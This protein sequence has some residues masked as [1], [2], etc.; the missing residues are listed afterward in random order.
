MKTSVFCATSLD[1]FLAREDGGMDWLPTECEPHGY[2]EFMAS[3]DAV[4]IGRKTFEW[5]QSYGQWV[6]DKPVVVLSSTLKELTWPKGVACELMSAS[7]REVVDRLSERGMKHL[8][9]DGGVTIRRFLEAGF[10]DSM[11]ITRIPILL[12][13]G[14]P[15]FGRLPQD[16]RFRHVETKAFPSGLVNS[17]YVSAD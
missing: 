3:V 8:Y 13:S 1:G 9:V 4:V 2:T 14:I 10:I 5:V 12:G 11:S 16:R 6:Y 15:L 17:V 7:P